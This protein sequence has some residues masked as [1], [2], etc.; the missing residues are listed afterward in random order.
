MNKKGVDTGPSRLIYLPLAHDGTTFT[1]RNS[2]HNITISGHHRFR[3]EHILG[4][5][6]LHVF[7]F[8]HG[9][10]KS[11]ISGSSSFR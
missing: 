5:D 3:R 8:L 7:D 2:W 1:I 4:L 11:S 6:K 9:V 10:G